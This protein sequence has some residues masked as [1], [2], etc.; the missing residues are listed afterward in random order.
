V[1]TDC[2]QESTTEELMPLAFCRPEIEEIDEEALG[3]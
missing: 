3:S 1:R 2:T